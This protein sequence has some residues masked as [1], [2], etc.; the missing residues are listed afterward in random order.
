MQH[1]QN[2]YFTYTAV[3]HLRTFH[4]ERSALK[5]PPKMYT[6]KILLKKYFHLSKF[7]FI[8]IFHIIPFRQLFKILKRIFINV[9]EKY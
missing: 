3:F 8:E 7:D 9:F 1:F 4:S 5:R 6:P 2:K